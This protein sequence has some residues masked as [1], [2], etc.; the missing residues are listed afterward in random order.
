MRK[1]IIKTTFFLLPII[2]VALSAEI[3]L[4]NIPNDYSYKKEYLDK[5]S[6]EIE[7]LILG[8]S[9]S[10]YGFNPDFFNSKAFNASHISQS[11]N[12][13]YG[14]LKKYE[15]N[16]DNLQ[17]V[18]LPI[19]YH[20]LYGKL[21]NGSESW[22][23]KNYVIYYRMNVANS[24]A[25]YSEVLS[26]KPKVNLKRLY[27]YYILRKPN[28]TCTKLGWGTSYK[29]ENAKDLVKT[30]STAAKRHTRENIHSK[31]YQ[32]I[33]NDNK[34][35]L[36]SIIDWCQKQNIR[37]LILTTPT[38]YT[39]RENINIEQYNITIE[40]AN[41]IASQYDNCIYVNLFDDTNFVA[42]DFYD[43]DHLSEIGAEKLSKLIDKK[44]NEWKNS[45]NR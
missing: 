21:E 27:S 1:F 3:L 13:D 33:F 45:T 2:V 10:F 22:R 43:A 5:H 6:N 35:L 36:A 25:D 12:Y 39:Y 11:L 32:D 24:L 44:I 15:D 18:I 30:G 17:T 31:K 8:S 28:L 16:L 34:L 20:T 23:I 14:I 26:N 38:F 29:S 42:K 9:H 40:I 41:K 7:T 19:S 4:R 37:V